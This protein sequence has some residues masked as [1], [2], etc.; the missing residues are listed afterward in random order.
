MSLISNVMSS[1]NERYYSK[2]AHSDFPH[3]RQHMKLLLLLV[4]PSLQSLNACIPTSPTATSCQSCPMLTE[5]RFDPNVVTSFNA[6][7]YVVRTFT[8]TVSPPPRTV[9]ISGYY[10]NGPRIYLVDRAMATDTVAVTCNAANT[11]WVFASP[12][13]PVELTWLRCDFWASG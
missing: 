13:G 12:T 8:C 3:Q 9:V 1:I 7:N 4:F 10:N 6:N 5:E 11:A 2:C